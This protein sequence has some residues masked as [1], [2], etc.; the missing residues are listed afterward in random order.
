LPA[1]SRTSTAA[2][3][4][5]TGRLAD[6][7]CVYPACFHSFISGFPQNLQDTSPAP[8]LPRALG[9]AAAASLL[10]VRLHPAPRPHRL[11]R[12]ERPQQ[13]RSSLAAQQR[14]G[15][16][17]QP[18]FTPLPVAGSSTQSCNQRRVF[19]RLLLATDQR[20]SCEVDKQPAGGLQDADQAAKPSPPTCQANVPTF[21]P[22]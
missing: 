8:D 10:Q 5:Q 19:A 9:T 15:G 20:A 16:G 21:V 13:L 7:C 18:W 12:P 17:H 4:W 6:A 22:R 11:S 14:A 3:C 1:T 2:A